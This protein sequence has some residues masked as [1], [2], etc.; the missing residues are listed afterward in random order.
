MVTF[1]SHIF[2]YTSTTMTKIKKT[3]NTK[4]W[5][6]NMEK[7]ELSDIVGGNVKWY[8]R[9]VERSDSFFYN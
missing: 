7:L 9:F 4:H 8:K 5:G 6:K 2:H 1:K 3:D